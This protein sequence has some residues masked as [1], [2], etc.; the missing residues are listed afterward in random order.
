MKNVFHNKKWNAGKVQM[1]V[2]PLPITLIKSKNNT[3]SDKYC[4]QIKLHREPTSQ[5]LDLYEFELELF[6]N[7]EPEEFLLSI[8]NFYMN[9]KASGTLASGAK[10]QYLCTLV[11][12]EVLNQFDTA[13]GRM[14]SR[15]LEPN[16]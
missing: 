14:T 11:C 9:L 8:R 7:V 4:V 2:E 6:D 10:N 16:P 1:H 12:R 3:K 5:K 15:Y 13:T